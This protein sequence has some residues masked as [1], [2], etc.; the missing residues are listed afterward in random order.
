MS[1]RV[2]FRLRLV[3]VNKLIRCPEICGE[4]TMTSSS[5]RMVVAGAELESQ[6]LLQYC[7][8]LPTTLL[9]REALRSMLY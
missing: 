8:N 3:V 6:Q 5:T 7:E 2:V 4:A 9:T 1:L